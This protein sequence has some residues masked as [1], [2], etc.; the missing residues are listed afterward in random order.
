[1]NTDQQK[2]L[3]QIIV[4]II[5][6]VGVFFIG[7]YTGKESLSSDL[8]SIPADVP[9]TDEQFQ[10]FW[11]VWRILSE[12]YVAAT[13]TDTQKRIWG[14][15]QGLTA[16]Q[17]DPYTVFFPPEESALFKSDIAGNFEG[18]GM[19]IALKDGFL[20]VVAPLKGS[21]AEKADV[22][23]G[24]KI[25]QID[26]Q[27]TTDLGV[28]K[29][30]KLIR[31]PKGSKVKILFARAG[32]SQPIEKSITRDVIDIP[33]IE[34]EVK[35]GTKLASGAPAPSGT[36]L[37]QDGI[38]VI[39]LFTFTAQAPDLF[40]KALREFIESGSHKLIVDLRSNPGGYLEAAVDMASWF[41]PSGT[42]I[43]T[44]DFGGKRTDNVYR[45][46]GYNIF[47][48]DLRLV[49]LV[50]AGSASAS[51]IFAGALQEHGVAKL[52][53]TKTFGKGSV[54]ELIPITPDTSLK[55]TIARW[56]TPKGRN[57]SKDGLDPD[58]EVKLTPKDIETKTDLQMEKA[59]E[60]LRKE[61]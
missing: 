48:K 2:K 47:G 19:E 16:S 61:P 49:I 4:G 58:F 40:R 60:I 26:G 31:G 23:S 21:P 56:L 13:T 17:N 45:S 24:D 5:I 20:T 50:D 32:A 42:T 34:T 18:V 44:E 7:N 3:V 25:I 36:G 14:A 55:V 22:H 30:V 10:S 38:F 57:L 15:I 43:V 1:M 6:L 51:E 28:D 46:K 53:G 11:K 12:K 29:A 59:V 9:V 33:T 27:V 54:Q 37:R 41:L 35:S 8:I 39:R 52:V